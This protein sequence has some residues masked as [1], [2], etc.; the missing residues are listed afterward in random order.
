MAV[1]PDSGGLT[2]RALLAAG[3]AWSGAACKQARSAR[4]PKEAIQAANDFVKAKLISPGTAVFGGEAD[5]QVE[6]LSAH[7]YR[8]K[9]IV[10]YGGNEGTMRVSFTCVVTAPAGNGEWSLEEMDFNR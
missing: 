5:T 2:R 7:R 1:E 9:G 10:D 6:E 4:D 3:V 8:V